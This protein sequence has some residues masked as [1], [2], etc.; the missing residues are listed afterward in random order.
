MSDK[1]NKAQLI[2]IHAMLAKGAS[3]LD[4]IGHAK[5]AF[6]L[7]LSGGDVYDLK[8]GAAIAQGRPSTVVAKT[9]AQHPFKR[10]P[11]MPDRQIERIDGHRRAALVDIN[12]RFAITDSVRQLQRLMQEVTKKEV[13]AETVNAACSCV[14]EINSTVKTAIMAAKFLSDR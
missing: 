11:S 5:K 10:T 7:K 9:V 14:R 1:P 4:V 13:S 6:G 3:A 2:E 8:R 12:E